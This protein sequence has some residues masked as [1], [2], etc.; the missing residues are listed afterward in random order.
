MRTKVLQFLLNLPDSEVDQFNQAFQ[1]YGQSP[2]KNTAIE[3][4]LNS[5]GYTKQNLENLLYD[6]QQLHSISDIEKIPVVD[7]E[8]LEPSEPD[9][10]ANPNAEPEAGIPLNA[11]NGNEPNQTDENQQK[12]DVASLRSQY[13]FLNDADC[14]NELKILI[15]DKITHYHAYRSAH[16]QLEKIKDGSLVVPP[17]KETKIAAAAVHHFEAGEAIGVELDHYKEKKELLGKH[18]IFN[19]LALQREVESLTQDELL[20]FVKNTPSY[21]SKN[22]KKLKEATSEKRIAELQEALNDRNAKLALVNKKLGV[23]AS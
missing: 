22:N 11:D 15:A 6:L 12:G 10:D 13:P 1:L 14:P 19:Q 17:A 4:Q 16:T 21:I 9:T 18:P 7:A 2:G 5:A 3:R 8:V 23:S 20:S